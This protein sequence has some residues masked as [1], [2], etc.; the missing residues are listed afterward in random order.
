[1]NNRLIPSRLVAGDLDA[2]VAL[3]LPL[4]PNGQVGPTSPL[5]HVCRHICA[6]EA[7]C[8][9]VQIDV[10]DPDF[11]AE[12]AS[13]Y[14][15]WSYQVPRFCYR[16]HF[17]SVDPGNVGDPLAV[18][19]QMAASEDS[20]LGFVT[21]RPIATSPVGATFLRPLLDGFVLSKETFPVN[22]AGHHFS[23]AATPFM[24]QDSA[25]GACAQA[26]IWM[27]LRTLQRKDGQ[28]TFNPAQITS[29]ATRFL[30]RGRTLPNRAGLSID[31]ITEAVRAAGYAPHSIPIKSIQDSATEECLIWA[32]QALYPYV[33]SGMPVLLALFPPE[34]DGHAVLLIGHR[35][36]A[37]PANL[38]S[39]HQVD[40]P[41]LEAPL[42]IYDASSWTEPFIIHN[43]NT[44][45]YLSLPDR[46]DSEAYALE[47]A[48]TAVPFLPADVFID[49]SEARQA[50]VM[51]FHWA[52]LPLLGQIA[53]TIEGIQLSLPKLVFRTYLQSRADFRSTVLTSSMGSDLKAYY[54][55]KWLPKRIW[56]T[57][58]NALDGYGDSPLGGA[59]RLGEI[60]LDPSSEPVE[61]HFLTIHLS[62]D[63]LASVGERGIIIDRDAFTG[64]IESFPVQLSNYAPLVRA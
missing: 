22:L 5:M 15:R 30:V 48:V 9:V 58:I 46:C 24:Q 41:Y 19:D 21:I 44:G 4:L 10:Q 1:M 52:L 55:M 56:V 31:Q 18:V 59:K 51:L 14:S 62:R 33:E 47:H 53:A 38:L 11:L 34:R 8:A 43:D 6:L 49:G 54:R 50:A 32:K 20:Y 28:A 60:L 3:F 42:V 13:Y 12:H 37:A 7:R 64:A 25:V 63:L 26:S 35:W 39:C 61:G 27:A 40:R 2:V 16:L 57:E 45:P 36:N 23:V 29:A 17:F